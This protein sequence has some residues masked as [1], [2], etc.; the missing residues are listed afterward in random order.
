MLE[1]MRAGRPRTR[2]AVAHGALSRVRGGSALPARGLE[3]A[4]L[5]VETTGLDPAAGARV[6]EIA[7]VRMRGD[8]TVLREF[9]T[10]VDPG[11]PMRGRE[12][13]GITDGDAAGA[14]R[15]GA[16]AG[17]L[18]GLFSGAV[19][20]GHNLDFE[21]AF[22]ASELVPAGLP[23][24][25]PGLC[26]LRA[27]RSQVDLDR[28]SLPRASLALN[29]HWPSGQHTALGDARACARILAEMLNT[30]PGELYYTGPAP[31]DLVAEGPGPEGR[32]GEQGGPVR[33]KSRTAAK[34]ALPVATV[35]PR[36]WRP[37]EL[38]AELC[39]G[40]FSDTDRA[41]ALKAARERGRRREAAAGAAALAGAVAAAGAAR[42]LLRVLR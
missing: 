28:Y 42:S 4:V 16:L 31:R 39:G 22:L 9:S 10:L 11:A 34:G 12:F 40:A 25:V 1:W 37:Q 6:C 29:G 24:G 23:E 32:G 20:V 14:P 36:R 33:L 13:H 18:A 15:V 19:V 26:T 8:G 38:P 2:G 35:W 17:E 27:L 7:V 3:Y 21:A 41:A 30:A 5:D